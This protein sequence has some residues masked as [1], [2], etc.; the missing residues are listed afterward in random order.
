MDLIQT[1]SAA[2]KAYVEGAGLQVYVA[3]SS[4]YVFEKAGVV[5]K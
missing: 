3:R 2:E 1:F 5:Y 4:M